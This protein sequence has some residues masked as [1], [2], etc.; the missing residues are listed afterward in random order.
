MK[1]FDVENIFTDIVVGDDK[2]TALA[3]LA[4]LFADKNRLDRVALTAGFNAREAESTTGF[5][6]GVAIPH[7]KVAGLTQPVVGIVTFETGVD[8]EALDDAPVE[9]AIV[10]I[11]PL[12][13]P[14]K[15]HLKVL[16]KFARKLMD[17]AFIH[18]LKQNRH[19]AMAL[20]TLVNDE[21][22]F[23]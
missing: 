17:D 21:I 10:L 22:E 15:T 3:I 14:N 7:A 9:I 20:Y 2:P 13:D 18:N 19:D 12:D 1:E 11:M 6:N 16:S 5:G 23:N 4:Q 8:W